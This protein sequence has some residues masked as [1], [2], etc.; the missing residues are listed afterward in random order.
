MGSHIDIHCPLVVGLLLFHIQICYPFCDD[1]IVK[2]DVNS[3]SC[4]LLINLYSL[5][6]S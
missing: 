4:L 5:T 6:L 3:M 2:E 1:Y